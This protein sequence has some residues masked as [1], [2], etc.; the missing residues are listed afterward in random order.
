[1]KHSPH[2][3]AL[4]PVFTLQCA[5]SFAKA[6]PSSR[7]AFPETLGKQ[8]KYV[9][10]RIITPLHPY[11]RDLFLYFGILRH[12]ARADYLIGKLAPHK[13]ADGVVDLLLKCGFGNHLVAWDEGELVSMRHAPNFR[14]QYHI[15]IFDDGEMRGHYEYTP[16]CHPLLHLREVGMEARTGYFLELLGDYVVPAE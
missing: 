7:L 13:S 1:V 5:R 16:E 6:P 3:V 12:E 14:Y 4:P 15:R 9:F 11:F 10:W 2:S 8:I